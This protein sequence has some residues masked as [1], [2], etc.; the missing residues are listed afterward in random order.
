MNNGLTLY[1]MLVD[2]NVSAKCHHLFTISDLTLEGCPSTDTNW[3]ER[4][5]H[6]HAN[7]HLRPQQYPQFILGKNNNML[8]RIISHRRMKINT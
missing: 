4:L 1:L 7:P 2:E 8:E 6:P 5:F 3:Y